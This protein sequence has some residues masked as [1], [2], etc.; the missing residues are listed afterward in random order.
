MTYKVFTR[1]YDVEQ[2]ASELKSSLTQADIAAFEKAKDMVADKSLLKWQPKDPIVFLL[3]LS[4]SMR[5]AGLERMLESILFIGEVFNKYDQPFEI[6]GFTTVSWSG[7]DV[8]KKWKEEGRPSKPGRL[9]ALRHVVF[10]SINE[11]WEEA[12]ENLAVMCILG[13]L[14]E[15]IQGEALEW[16]YNRTKPRNTKTTV[17][18]FSDGGP[19]DDATVQ[20][21][22][23]SLLDD[24]YEQMINTFL[25]DRQ[26]NLMGCNL[27]L[28]QDSKVCIPN[29]FSIDF[30]TRPKFIPELTI[31]QLASKLRPK[32]VTLTSL[33]YMVFKCVPVN[34]IIAGVDLSKQV[35]GP[36]SP[37]HQIGPQ[38]KALVKKGFV[39]SLKKGNKNFYVRAPEIKAVLINT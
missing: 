22:S 3:D 16:V 19:V 33:Q 5:G 2:S 8:F 23:T 38:I 7:G 27:Y 34:G 18:L 30:N 9:N 20:S 39:L 35:H 37:T 17:V 26:F 24:H 10:K 25:H 32:R 12:K 29:S 36:N 21:N 13:L 14:K 15:N 28:K 6:L 11:P 1:E 4:G 31:K